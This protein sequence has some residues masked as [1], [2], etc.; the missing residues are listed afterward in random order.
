MTSINLRE[1]ERDARLRPIA[2]DN[3]GTLEQCGEY[4]HRQA[5][6]VL[7]LVA[8]VR[9]ARRLITQLELVLYSE[10]HTVNNPCPEAEASAW[11][12]RVND[13]EA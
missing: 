9:E 12:A 4:M 6:H 5:E 10:F 8:L 2:I 3:L 13:E 7:A 1:I 11:L